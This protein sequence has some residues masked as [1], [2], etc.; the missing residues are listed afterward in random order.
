MPRG[1]RARYSDVAGARMADK[2][3]IQYVERVNSSIRAFYA[4]AARLAIRDRRMA[5]FMLRML[6]S[7]L[8]A[9][10]RRRMWQER[11]VRV[12]PLMIISATG[13]CNL[14]CKGCYARQHQLMEEDM[15]A[16]RLVETLAEADEIGVSMA[17]L[18]GGEPL[19]RPDL[20]DITSRFK[21]MMF[22]LFTNGLLI[23]R[24][25]AAELRRHKNVVPVISLDG[26]H[27]ATDERRGAGV[28]DTLRKVID[29]VSKERLAFGVSVM[30]TRRN[31]EEATG[32][33]FVRE[34][35]RQGCRLFFFVEYV[36]FEADTEDLV[37]TKTQ[38]AGMIETVERFKKELPALF[39]VF[40]GNEE[41]FGG[42][43]SSGRGFVH[44]SAGGRLEPCPFAPFSDIDLKE[45]PLRE[46]LRSPF[47]RAIRDNHEELKET[48][49]GCALW[50]KREWVKSLLEPHM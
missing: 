24:A 21:R 11:G 30:F 45:R 41:K 31:L 43:L 48:R 22:T 2:E 42:C 38:R 17:I 6:W 12:P 15:R 8:R 18:A 32:D 13:R 47:L 7:Q 3:D 35:V 20:L 39:I 49:G 16:E 9:M 40:P 4:R 1:G 34:L 50:E 23:D 36:P 44:V 27:A 26:P 33:A 14:A 19:L 37:P 29:S 25:M 28:Y 5:V 46:A 10:R